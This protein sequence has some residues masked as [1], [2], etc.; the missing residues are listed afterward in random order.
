MFV[1]VLTFSKKM[2]LF[3]VECPFDFSIFSSEISTVWVS[4]Q[5]MFSFV[6]VFYA[7]AGPKQKGQK[8]KRAPISKQKGQKGQG[9]KDT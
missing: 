7:L 4:F 8:G 3:F 9:Q 6:V 1:F 5:N 2:V